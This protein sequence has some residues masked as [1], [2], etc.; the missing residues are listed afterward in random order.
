MNYVVFLVMFYLKFRSLLA[1]LL[2]I[3]KENAASFAILSIFRSYPD[4]YNVIKKPIS[5]LKIKTKISV[6]C[7]FVSIPWY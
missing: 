6:C 2:L 3:Y 5:L 4:Y 7:V 1:V